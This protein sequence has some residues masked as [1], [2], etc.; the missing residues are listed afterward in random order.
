MK[1]IARVT[2]IGKNRESFQPESEVDL[3]RDEA[4][5]LV[6][7]RLA[8]LPVAKPKEPQKPESDQGN[9]PDSGGN[10]DPVT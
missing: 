9:D 10:E 5:S 2:I 3:P 7:R 8:S 6:E 1:I 4:E